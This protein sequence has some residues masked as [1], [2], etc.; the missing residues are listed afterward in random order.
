MVK[1]TLIFGPMFSGKS[2]ELIA[3]IR[4]L[5]AINKTFLVIKPSIDYRYSKDD[6]IVSHN[7]DNEACISLNNLKDLLKKDLSDINTIFI[8]EGQF[9]SDLKDVVIEL[10]EQRN[11]NVFISGLDGDSDRNKFGQVVDL[12]PYCDDIIRTKALCKMCGDGTEAIFS[13]YHAKKESQVEVGGGDKYEPLC[14]KHYLSLN[15]QT[16]SKKAPGT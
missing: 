10:V 11:I 7:K 14:R 1:L 16:E 5:Q 8:D 12:I 6:F 3:N 4:R 9:F 13:H 15:N 2:S